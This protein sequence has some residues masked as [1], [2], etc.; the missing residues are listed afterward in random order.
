MPNSRTSKGKTSLKKVDKT[1]LLNVE[2]YTHYLRTEYARKTNNELSR[3]LRKFKVVL[4]VGVVCSK[5]QNPPVRK[6]VIPPSA[7]E[8][9]KQIFCDSVGRQIR[10]TQY[11]GH[12]PR[13]WTSRTDGGGADFHKFQKTRQFGTLGPQG[14]TKPDTAFGDGRRKY[15]H[16]ANGRAT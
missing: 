10:C 5:N 12:Y 16:F 6:Q 2:S 9:V 11:C 8:H 4:L 15:T 13:S 3:R 1:K 14:D 7:V